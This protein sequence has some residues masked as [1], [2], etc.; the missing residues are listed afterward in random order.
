VLKNSEK[1]TIKALKDKCMVKLA[2]FIIENKQ[3]E[4]LLNQLTNQVNKNPESEE[5][6]DEELKETLESSTH[7]NKG[8]INI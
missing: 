6:I 2:P 5:I 8:T 4:Y 7:I 3:S 1:Y